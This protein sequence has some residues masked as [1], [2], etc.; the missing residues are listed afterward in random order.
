MTDE[1]NIKMLSDVIFASI[2]DCVA[3]NKTGNT[4]SMEG[5]KITPSRGYFVSA[6][7]PSLVTWVDEI[8]PQIIEWFLDHSENHLN[9][10]TYLGFWIH[11]D[12]LYLNVS[13]YFPRKI[14]AIKF[15]VSNKQKAIWDCKNSTEIFI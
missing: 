6:E 15:G 10:Y 11:K 4:F 9:R 14:D 8:N 13:Y 2:V 7:E 5:D 1:I 3:K 12:K